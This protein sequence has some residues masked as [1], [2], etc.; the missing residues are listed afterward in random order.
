MIKALKKLL[1]W[2]ET[3]LMEK[4][5]F[6]LTLGI[7]TA[8]VFILAVYNFFISQFA[9]SIAAFVILP[10]L[11]WIWYQLRVKQRYQLALCIFGG[12]TYPAIAISFFLK[13]GIS[14][15]TVYLFFIM[16]L[17]LVC[18]SPTKLAYFWTLVNL[19]FFMVLFYIGLFYGD[20]ISNHYGDDNLVYLDHTFIYIASIIGLTF[21]VLTL[22]NFYSVQ[23]R[24]ADI[25]KRE[26]AVANRELS[27]ANLQK[28]KIIAIISHDL[29]NPLM[30]ILQALELINSSHDLTK[31]EI[32]FLHE[33]L[34]KSTKRTHNLLEDI[35]EWSTLELKNQ[36]NKVK[37]IDLKTLFTDTLGIMNTIAH[38]KGLELEVEYVNNPEV[39]IETDRLL[40]IVR[41][42]IQNA[43]KFTKEGGKVK[44]TINHN[45]QEALIKVEDTGIGIPANKISG[46]SEL[47][48]K[49]T[50][51]TANEKGTGMGL[52]LCYQNAGKLG[53][54]I[55]VT[56][57]V[58]K[59][60]TFIL[61]VPLSYQLPN[62]H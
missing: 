45:E 43:I 2:Q 19:V 51:G 41:N 29:K 31:E 36:T 9:I 53:G 25:K 40:L 10:V 26:L 33:E 8:Y 59:G 54:K 13:D 50:F 7:L 6:N 24:D 3:I 44:V 28:D 37:A 38:Q 58:G 62:P 12:L 16:Q 46:L 42:L 30:S 5:V 52:Y 21:L 27:N 32:S 18:I 39:Q 11:W 49:S 22:K 35:L 60:T 55:S 14:G 34:L 1:F 15:P 47:E 20:R 57:K 48:V 4:W 23:K 56:S 17:V 61:A